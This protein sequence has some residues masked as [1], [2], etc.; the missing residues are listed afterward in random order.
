MKFCLKF[1]DQKKFTFVGEV[2]W[3]YVTVSCLNQDEGLYRCCHTLFSCIA[4]GTSSVMLPEVIC[5]SGLGWS[6]QHQ[7]AQLM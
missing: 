4:T 1:L 3:E 6:Y 2:K 5:W 7:T